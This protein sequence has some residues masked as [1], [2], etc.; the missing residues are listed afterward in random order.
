MS[1]IHRSPYA[2]TWYPGEEKE[3]G[4]LIEGALESARARMG[5]YLLPNPI[6]FV[7]PHAGLIYSGIV[8]CAAYRYL[9]TVRP[10]RSLYSGAM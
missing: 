10:R 4:Q 6:A 8:A 7:V 9:Q 1:G 3:L 5:P 2:G